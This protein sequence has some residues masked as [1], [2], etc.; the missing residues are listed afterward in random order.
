MIAV[1]PP[2]SRYRPRPRRASPR[3]R[4]SLATAIAK[5]EEPC[6]A[7]SA[8]RGAGRAAAGR[9]RWWRVGRGGGGVRSGRKRGRTAALGRLGERDPLRVDD[10]VTLVASAGDLF[11]V[12]SRWPVAGRATRHA[13]VRDGRPARI[14]DYA[15][16]TGPLAEDIREEGIRSAVGTPIHRR[17]SPLGLD[18]RRLQ[19]RAASA[20]DTE[21][22]LRSFTEL[23]ATAI[24]NA[25]SRGGSRP[26][27]RGAGGVAADGDAGCARDRGGG[28]VRGGSGRGRRLLSVDM[29]N[30]CRYESTA[31]SRSSR[32]GVSTFRLAVR[33]PLGGRRT[34][35]SSCSRRAARPGSATM[36]MR[37]ARSLSGSANRGSAR[38][39]D[40]DRRR[41]RLWGVMAAGSSQEQPLPADTEA[42]LGSFTSW[43]RRRIANTEAR[44]EVG[45]LV[46]EQ[47][48]LRRVAT[49]VAHGQR[50]QRCSRR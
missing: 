42:R 44:T 49:L 41:G 45:R 31:R 6:R 47:G 30:M 3:S 32:A 24:A 19:P 15:E 35:P 14:D 27:G 10:T 12:A 50:R 34:W 11:P 40:T 4:S 17:G 13:R 2:S 16:A 9:D 22:R 38:R 48:A 1:R 23:V 26:A 21:A 20:A 18:H 37:P 5:A 28:G 25:E 39:S 29:A 33:W 46:D 7:R 36:P 43:W 8:R